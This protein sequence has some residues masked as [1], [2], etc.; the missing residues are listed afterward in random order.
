MPALLK[1]IRQL[2]GAE[3]AG[4]LWVNSAGKMTSLYAERL[5]PT[6][7]MR[8]YFERYYDSG[9][10]SFRQTFIERAGRSEPVTSTS[11]SPLIERSQYYNEVLRHLDA[12][13]VMY[14]IV[15]E[16][17]EAVGQ[18]SLY[19]SK[20]SPAFSAEDRSEL[21]SIMRYVVHGLV[22]RGQAH[23]AFSGFADTDDDAIFLISVEGE[24]RHQSL[25]AQKLLLLATQGGLAE[26]RWPAPRK[27]P[28]GRCD[29]W[30]MGCKTSS[31][32]RK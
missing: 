21:A 9:E 1:A 22:Q 29:T 31:R 7:A 8:L 18:L 20:S 26:S 19:R 10:L 5:L 16:H 6:P 17:G 27:P 12:H 15:R 28:A 4:F 23:S 32:V 30:P 14:G 2:V 25:A 11:A 24:V 13:H 3:S